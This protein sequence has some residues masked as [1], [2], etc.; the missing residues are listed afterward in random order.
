[1]ATS[2]R[3]IRPRVS[4]IIP[5]FNRHDLICET[6]DSVL[7]QTLRGSEIVV[8]DDGSTDDTR[9]ILLS[10]F[11][12]RIKYVYQ[13]NR[14]RSAARNRGISESSG[15]YILF[16][17][18]DDLLL[19]QALELLSSYLD[20]HAAVGVVYSDGYY[21]DENGESIARISE[22]RPPLRGE[23]ML[24]S[25]VLSNVIVAPHSAMLRRG[26]LGGLDYPYFDEDLSGPEDAD[27]WIRLA[28]SGCV[29]E[30]L[31]ELTCKY[32]MHGGNTYSAQSEG[33]RRA[34][35]SCG[36]CWRKVLNSV[37][38]P[39]LSSWTQ[40]TFLR[41][42]FLDYMAPTADTQEEI[43]ASPNFKKMRPENQAEALYFAGVDNIVREHLTTLGR[44]RIRKALALQPL[45]KYRVILLISYLG[46]PAL[47][48]IMS[49]RRRWADLGKG[50]VAHSPIYAQFLERASS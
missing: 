3:T 24:E 16:L 50:Q 14:G 15:E 27:L 47:K 42:Y 18:S 37:Y 20:A 48:L 32:R 40:R 12:Q 45:W 2:E 23:S 34:I 9:E 13:E 46:W 5:T 11:G 43:F 38:F 30:Y 4:V 25:L 19:P 8:V 36:A 28:H 31:D 17:D 35:Q 6:I 44:E 22:T 41:M 21:C 10:R 7:R 33:L 29:F 39:S 49:L 1:M 26:C